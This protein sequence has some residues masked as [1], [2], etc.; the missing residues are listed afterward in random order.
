MIAVTVLSLLLLVPVTLLV[1]QVLMALPAHR[2]RAMPAGRRPIAVVLVPAHDEASGIAGTLHSIAAQLAPGD[3]LLVVADNCTDDTAALAAAAGAEVIERHDRER[4]GKGYALAFGLRYLEETASPSPL[5]WPD[6]LIVID[7]DC[8]IA[9]GT[10]ERLARGAAG[11]RPMQ[12]AYLMQAQA[13]AGLPTRIAE[14]AWLVKNLVRP[15]GCLRLGLPCQLMGSGM[16]FPW[17]LID[18][19]SL[20]S[21]Q[22]VEDYVLGLELARRGAAPHFCPEARVTSHFPASAA[23]SARQ[24]KRWEHGH[25]GVILRAPRLLSEA[26]TRPNAQLFALALDMCVPP[27]ALLVLM[28]AALFAAAI[29]SGAPLAL[30]LAGW[31]VA[32]VGGAVLLAWARYGRHIVS[33]ASLAYAPVYALLKLPLYFAFVRRRQVAWERAERDA[34]DITTKPGSAR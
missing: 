4:R 17:G 32:L 28:S 27:L 29:A 11:G 23:G 33:A 10:L 20:A 31:V 14:L 7:A 3:R 24:R 34:D 22:L 12:A 8:R 30:W 5:S 13:G 2:A 15:L 25:L 18:A 1:L 19:A 21:G 16:A 26:V 9:S 6:A